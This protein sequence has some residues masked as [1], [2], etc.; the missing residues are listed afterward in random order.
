MYM[1]IY[2]YIMIH[3][4]NSHGLAPCVKVRF[5]FVNSARMIDGFSTEHLLH[6]LQAEIRILAQLQR[7]VLQRVP[8]P[9]PWASTV[10]QHT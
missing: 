1:Y 10:V 5:H 8:I 3:G 9:H 7:G 2:I 4:G 6:R